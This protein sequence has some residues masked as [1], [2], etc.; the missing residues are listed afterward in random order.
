M[1]AA[2]IAGNCLSVFSLLY[3]GSAV[4]SLSSKISAMATIAVLVFC[5]IDEITAVPLLPQPIIPS[6]MAEFAFVPKTIE[7]LK[8]LT[9]D[10]AAAFLRKSLRLFFFI[11]LF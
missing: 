11:W 2:A 4:C 5:T 7:G 8:I 9:A 10:I 3:L 1:F 6:L